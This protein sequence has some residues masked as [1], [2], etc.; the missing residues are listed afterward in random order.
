[1]DL[2]LTLGGGENTH[3]G[4]IVLCEAGKE[5]KTLNRKGHFDW[6]VAKPI[7]EK[8]SKKTGK[9]VVC[10]AGIHVNNATKEEIEILKKNCKEI[11]EKI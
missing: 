4:S 3:V 8:I 9:V 6:M 7:A 1:E 2:V 5:P 11:E 10:I